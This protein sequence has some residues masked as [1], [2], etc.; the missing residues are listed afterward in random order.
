M[1]VAIAVLSACVES[2][3]TCSTVGHERTVVVT[4]APEWRPSTDRVISL[5]CA[6]DCG[7]MNPSL[8]QSVQLD[9]LA[10]AR[11]TLPTSPS[12]VELSVVDD[13][14]VAWEES[15]DLAWRRIGGTREC[16]GSAEARVTVPLS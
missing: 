2:G 12:V 8:V 4:L 13:G 6:K 1:L 10:E 16:G 11:F 15:V 9:G 14:L 3:G 5:A 7:S